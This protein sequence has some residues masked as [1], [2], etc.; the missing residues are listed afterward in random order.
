[1]LPEIA[2]SA[3]IVFIA[4]PEAVKMTYAELRQTMESLLRKAG[5]L[6]KTDRT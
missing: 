2:A 5:M 3:D 4:R 1:M 6:P